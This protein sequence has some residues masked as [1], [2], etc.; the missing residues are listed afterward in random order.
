MD[1]IF[2]LFYHPNFN[3]PNPV[4]HAA[5]SPTAGIIT[6]TATSSR[7]AQFGSKVLW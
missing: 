4:I 3:T 1:E 7:Q 5:P 6:S 2:N